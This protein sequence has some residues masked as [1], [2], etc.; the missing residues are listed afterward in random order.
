MF[1]FLEGVRGKKIEEAEYIKCR[2]YF[3]QKDSLH[4]IVIFF[5]GGY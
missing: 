3:I 4:G 5:E 2:F 1:Q